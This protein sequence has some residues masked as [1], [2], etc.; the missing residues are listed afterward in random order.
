MAKTVGYAVAKEDF[1]ITENGMGGQTYEQ[2]IKKGTTFK[3]KKGLFRQYVEN[4]YGHFTLAEVG[5]EYYRFLDIIENTE[6]LDLSNRFTEQE[7]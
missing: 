3:L 2:P 5:T 6:G 4:I 1:T 7:V